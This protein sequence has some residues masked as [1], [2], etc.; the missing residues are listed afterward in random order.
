MAPP[1]LVGGGFGDAGIP[2]RMAGPGIYII[3][4]TD[5]N[6]RYVGIAADVA[7][8][9]REDRLPT[10]VEMGYS[11]E[12]MSKIGVTWGTVR[13]KNT[14]TALV[15][16]PI[17]VNVIPGAGAFDTQI[18]GV[19]VKL[20]RLL[21]RFCMT[22]FGAGGSVSNNVLIRAPYENPTR[23]VIDVSVEYGSMGGLFDAKTVNKNWGVGVANQW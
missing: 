16:G 8:R 7:R 13:I 5:T 6:N 12:Q 17:W 11:T 19:N 14:P 20:E 9:F 23:N 3:V 4:N 15:P 18:D 2:P 10:V 21:I 22:Q 1:T